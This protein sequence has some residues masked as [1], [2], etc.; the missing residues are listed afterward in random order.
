MG[1]FIPAIRLGSR[2]WSWWDLARGGARLA[3][4]GL[5]RSRRLAGAGRAGSWAR[6]QATR[7][8]LKFLRE[9]WSRLA[10]VVVVAAALIADV[11]CLVTAGFVRGRT[12][13]VLGTAVVAMRF[14]LVLEVTGTAATRM[15][16]TAERWTVSEL[17][18]YG[19][20]VG[21]SSTITC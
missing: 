9:N 12:V 18:P 7:R 20:L 2:A 11:A 16:P 17:R 13:G 1:A 14:V 3:L 10:V 21:G 8:Q 4:R 5:V 15:G 19:A 6:I